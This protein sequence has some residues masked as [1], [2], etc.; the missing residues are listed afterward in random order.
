MP[1]ASKIISTLKKELIN[2]FKLGNDKTYSLR[3]LGVPLAASAAS[4]AIRW[5]AILL[6]AMVSTISIREMITYWAFGTLDAFAL[7]PFFF[8]PSLPPLHTF[9][10]SPRSLRLLLS[11]PSL[12]MAI[13]FFLLAIS[14]A[15]EQSL[16]RALGG[17][18]GWLEWVVGICDGG[19]GVGWWLR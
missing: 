18:F 19:D 15:F 10:L 14:S 8:L 7:P 13:L 17:D 2:I 12:L 3:E 4:S 16:L 11:K 6:L 1:C 5:A 9:T